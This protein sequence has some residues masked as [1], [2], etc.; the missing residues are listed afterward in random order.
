[1][2]ASECMVREELFTV[3]RQLDADGDGKISWVELKTAL[4]FV[5]EDV[6]DDELREIV[7]QLDSDGDG[8]I[9]LEE[10]IR[11]INTEERGAE[12]AEKE[13]VAAFRIF[14]GR[15]GGGSTTPMG[16]HRMM[17]RL[18]L[19]DVDNCLT[20]DHC[21]FIISQVDQDGDGVV[22]LKEF[23]RVMMAAVQRCSFVIGINKREIIPEGLLVVKIYDS[24]GDE[25]TTFHTINALSS[26]PTGEGV[27]SVGS[28]Y[29]V[30]VTSELKNQLIIMRTG[31]A[32]LNVENRT[33]SIISTPQRPL[34]P[35]YEPYCHDCISDWNLT[36]YDGNVVLVYTRYL[37]LW[38]LDENNNSWVEAKPF[39]EIPCNHFNTN[40]QVESPSY[41][42]CTIMAWRIKEGHKTNKLPGSSWTFLPAIGHLLE[43]I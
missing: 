3:F 19:A 8:C 14:E 25:W 28:F 17:C 33:W 12:E 36:G 40:T 39:P 2:E 9:D 5:G 21:T 6:G 1:A 32:A 13:L 41:C 42:V 26:A 30:S 31:V 20:L 38:K 15:E 29:W 24:K 7:K 23:K 11:L 16:L 37:R 10:F 27:F 35:K 22:N 18:S 34:N 4:N 43:K